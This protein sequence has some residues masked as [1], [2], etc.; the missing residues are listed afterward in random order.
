MPRYDQSVSTLEARIDD[1][2]NRL[3]DGIVSFDTDTAAVRWATVKLALRIVL[4]LARLNRGRT[5]ADA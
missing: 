2:L 3:R 1:N 5:E 4:A